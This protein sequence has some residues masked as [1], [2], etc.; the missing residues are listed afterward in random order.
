M[1]HATV[2]GTTVYMA[3]EVM[4]VE[5]EAFNAF[6]NSSD[7]RD[8]DPTITKFKRKNIIHTRYKKEGCDHDV[9]SGANT[10]AD[11]DHCTVG[12]G[13]PSIQPMPT[14]ESHEHED[15]LLDDSAIELEK[16][17]KNDSELSTTHVVRKQTVVNKAT[18]EHE[19]EVVK[20]RRHGYGR[21]ADVWSLG[22]TLSEMSTGRSPYR[23]AAAAIYSVCVSKKYPSFPDEMS[24]DAHSFLS[25]YTVP[26]LLCFALPCLV[27][28]CL[29]V[30]C[31][32]ISC[33]TLSYSALICI[34]LP[35]GQCRIKTLQL[36]IH[37]IPVHIFK[38]AIY[39]LL[40]CNERCLVADPR[41]RAGCEELLI[42]SFLK[43]QVCYVGT[44]PRPHHDLNSNVLCRHATPLQHQLQLQ[45]FLTSTLSRVIA[46]RYY[47]CLCLLQ[48]VAQLKLQSATH[49]CSTIS[50]RPPEPSNN[51][52]LK[53]IREEKNLKSVLNVAPCTSALQGRG[54][55]SRLISMGATDGW[56]MPTSAQS[57]A[58]AGTTPV[59]VQ[60]ENKNTAQSDAKKIILS[61][62]TP[63][64]Q[65]RSTGRP[66][67]VV[68]K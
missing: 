60:K 9:G 13:H 19:S 38:T 22:V 50:F 15:I 44:L 29:T 66:H 40:Q 36:L 49:T 34:G 35:C 59:Q 4:G 28:S 39:G 12:K 31:F 55:G 14:N 17:N 43:P 46:C 18:H 11:A 61:K 47:V 67:R 33:K 65:N 63:S 10:G 57:K 26:F 68:R 24:T 56:I 21:K 51:N 54:K 16:E 41:L 2:T 45:R 20:D 23:T 25:R 8:S 5:D 3:P 27:M 42:H 32:T 53:T 52:D 64:I 30:F 1:G 48:S 6:G 62:T 37:L 58:S 7:S